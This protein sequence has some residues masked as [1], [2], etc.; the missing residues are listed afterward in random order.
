MNPNIVS[1]P[2]IPAIH[3][4]S[5]N[6]VYFL[7]PIPAHSKVRRYRTWALDVADDASGG[8][9]HELNTDL[10]H[11]ST[12]TYNPDYQKISPSSAAIV[13]VHTGSSQDTGNLYE[14]NWDF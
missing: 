11:T 7:R 14:L 5:T 3:S 1:R 4:T 12:R 10:G 9:V 8:I 13:E 6:P 2:S